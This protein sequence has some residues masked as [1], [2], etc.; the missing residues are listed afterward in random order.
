MDKNIAYTTSLPG[1]HIEIEGEGQFLYFSGTGYLGISR[2]PDFLQALS[3][4]ISR[5]GSHFGGS[6]RSNIQFAIIEEAEYELAKIAGVE[7]AVTFSSGSLAGQMVSHYFGH[8][9]RLLL[10]PGTH[11]ALWTPA[12]RPQ[13][14]NF[15]DWVEDLPARMVASDAPQALFLNSLDPLYA[16][17]YNLGWLGSFMDCYPDVLI[18]LDDSH[19]WGVMGKGGRS[20]WDAIPE[21]HYPKVV[22]VSSLG[23]AYGMPGGMLTGSAEVLQEIFNSPFFGGASP[24]SLAYYH[25]FIQCRDLFPLQL[26]K[27]QTLIGILESE[28]LITDIFRHIEG[29]PVFYTTQEDIAAYLYKQKILI[30][31]FRYPGPSDPLINRVVVN[32]LHEQADLELLIASLYSW[33]MNQ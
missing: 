15:E 20:V 27:L 11:P 7:R 33:K 9:G 24:M 26:E 25:A 3:E 12:N 16:S 21:K 14:G 18:I 6:R 22:V 13:T 31:S 2:N 5:Y 30:S 29:H 23:K 17:R 8:K 1:R 10:A 19:G 28:P 4:G 32:S